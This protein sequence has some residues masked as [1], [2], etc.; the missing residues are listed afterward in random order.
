MSRTATTLGV[1]L[2]LQCSI[3]PACL[4]QTPTTQALSIFEDLLGDFVIKEHSI[5][6]YCVRFDVVAS[7]SEG[8]EPE[9]IE[10][11]TGWLAVDKEK[12]CVRYD[13]Q[14]DLID[15][16]D[17]MAIEAFR[18]LQ[19]QQ[20]FYWGQGDKLLYN[21]VKLDRNMMEKGLG[22]MVNPMMISFSGMLASRSVSGRNSVLGRAIVDP[23]DLRAAWM[24]GDR[25]SG[26]I[27]GKKECSRVFTIDRRSGG[28]IECHVYLHPK[29]LFVEVPSKKF[30]SA[31]VTKTKWKELPTLGW[32]PIEAEDVSKQG[33]GDSATRD[34]IV[35]KIKWRTDEFSDQVFEPTDLRPKLDKKTTLQKMF[36]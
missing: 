10:T 34:H 20:D 25:V 8:V 13:Y 11:S 17:N 3:L 21:V 24:D 2:V 18:H 14:S 27:E 32:R 7:Q 9:R 30:K 31:V 35:T 15:E 33:P 16:H 4:S 6:R 19:L 23:D 22:R 26:S 1:C 28:V 29:N 5:R 36:D 12:K